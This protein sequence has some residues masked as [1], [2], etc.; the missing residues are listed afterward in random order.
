[1]KGLLRW[2]LWAPHSNVV[3][4]FTRH[5]VTLSGRIIRCDVCV[6]F[7]E[8]RLS[9]GLSIKNVLIWLAIKMIICKKMIVD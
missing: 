9:G 2:E 6:S 4:L 1:M 3:F 5:D 7:A 8:A